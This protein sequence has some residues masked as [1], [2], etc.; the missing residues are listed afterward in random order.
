MNGRGIGCI[1][2]PDS[3]RLDAQVQERFDLNEEPKSV[4]AGGPCLAILARVLSKDRDQGDN[5]YE[6]SGDRS[7][8]RPVDVTPQVELCA[9]CEAGGTAQESATEEP[10]NPRNTRHVFAIPLAAQRT[11]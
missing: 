7:D 11:L 1:E 3:G 9:V 4:I 10:D 6:K 8:G 2:G 5:D